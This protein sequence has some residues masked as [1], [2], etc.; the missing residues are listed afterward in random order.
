[1][2]EHRSDETIQR[3]DPKGDIDDLIFCA[4]QGWSASSR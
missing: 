3:T 1:M 2:R 4:D